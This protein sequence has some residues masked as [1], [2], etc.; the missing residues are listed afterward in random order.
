[1]WR[2]LDSTRRCCSKQNR[3]SGGVGGCYLWVP[4][5]W[6]TWQ[7]GEVWVERS[8][9]VAVVSNTDTLGRLKNGT[10]KWD[11]LVSDT[12]GGEGNGAAAARPACAHLTSG[13]FFFNFT[14]KSKFKP[15]LNSFAILIKPKHQKITMHQHECTNM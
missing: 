12:R 9:V 2:G 13:F 4:V 6:T 15:N 14:F 8:R 5:A 10:N 7:G 11:Q 1:M 3:E